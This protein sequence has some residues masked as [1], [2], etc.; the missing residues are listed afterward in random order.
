MKEAVAGAFPFEREELDT[1]TARDMFAD[2]PYKLE[3]IEGLTDAESL[4]IYR[5][6]G[7]VDLCQGPHVANTED[8]PA[9]KLLS[10]AG[11]YW[12]G[13]EKRPMLQRIYGTAFESEELLSDHLARLEEAERRDHRTLGRQ[14]GL[15]TIHEEIGPGLVVWHPK[16]GRVRSLIE[17]YWK[18]IHFRRGYDVVY[19]PHIGR[20][21]LWQ[22]SGHLDFYREGMY[23]PVEVDEQEY[24][25][26][27]MNCPFHI[28]IYR[29]ACAATASCRSGSPSWAPCTATSAAAFCTGL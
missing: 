23:A 26:K 8:I 6:N 29:S 15:Y 20:S 3:L 21:T 12:R 24:F 2:Q 7:F 4:S 5:H 11:A 18:D 16:G 25:L 17:D 10:V 19:S 28:T 27:P 9:L 22:T 1:A 13:D 14:L